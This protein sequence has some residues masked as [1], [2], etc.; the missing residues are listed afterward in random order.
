[1]RLPGK[2]VIITGAGSGIGRASAVLFAQEGAK[3]V[4][5]D[6]VAEAADETVGKIEDLGGQAFAF[7]VDVTREDEVEALVAAT[8]ERFKRLDVLFNNAGIAHLGSVLD[9]GVEDWEQVFAVNVR[10]SFLCA[11]HAARAMIAVGGGVI[12]NM[13]SVAGL[14]GVPRMAAYCAAKGAIV[15][16]TKNMALDLAP[17]NIRVNCLAPGTTLTPLGRFLLGSDDSEEKQRARLAKYPLGRFGQPEEIARAALFLAC[18]ESS[19]VTGACLT[20][21]G[22]MTAM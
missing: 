20:V 1:M 14:V 10:G 11:K 12:I 13:A 9:T 18:D 3:I 22:G 2:V 15:P 17:Y 7:A 21:D 6:V 16:L 19:F 4:A 8:L 5:A